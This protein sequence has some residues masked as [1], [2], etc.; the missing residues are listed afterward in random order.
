MTHLRSALEQQGLNVEHL[1]VQST[2]ASSSSNQTSAHAQ[3][4]QGQ[5]QQ[6][7]NGSATDGQSRGLFGGQS[8][9][10]SSQD[11]GGQQED[12]QPRSFEREL[13]NLVA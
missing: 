12:R 2:P 4:Q 13:L 9:R 5:Q 10:G 6:Q 11:G 1:N 7:Q 3:H 8:D